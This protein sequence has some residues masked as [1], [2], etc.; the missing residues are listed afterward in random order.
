ME[1]AEIEVVITDIASTRGRAVRSEDEEM[2][3]RAERKKYLADA[4]LARA[5]VKVEFRGKWR[6]KRDAQAAALKIKRAER[7]KRNQAAWRAK[8]DAQV[9][10]TKALL[11][12]ALR[13]LRR[14]GVVLPPDLAVV[15]SQHESGRSR[16]IGGKRRVVQMLEGTKH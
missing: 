12:K 15:L 16:G 7:K 14:K 10:A 4:A 1:E 5:E 6:A 2:R 9:D 8:H 11:F 3:R 13:L